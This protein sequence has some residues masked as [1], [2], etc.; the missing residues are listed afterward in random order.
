M[1]VFNSVASA[2]R[3]LMTAIIRMNG[4]RY[5]PAKQLGLSRNQT[6]FL[7]DIEKRTVALKSKGKT[8]RMAISDNAS[9]QAL[10]VLLLEITKGLLSYT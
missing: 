1:T 2:L 8:F 3:F 4:R 5:I 7:E 6:P 10:K 9:E